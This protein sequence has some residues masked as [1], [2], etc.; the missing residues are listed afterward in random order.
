M[1]IRDRVRAILTHVSDRFIRR[2]D[3]SDA[4][5]TADALGITEQ[6]VLE[7][8]N[9]L[10]LGGLLIVEQGRYYPSIYT[11][12]A[13]MVEIHRRT[14]SLFAEQAGKGRAA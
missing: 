10:R 12:R 4:P 3:A 8:M 9:Q 1:C 2:A 6:N 11:L 7:A 13:H 5:Q 14:M